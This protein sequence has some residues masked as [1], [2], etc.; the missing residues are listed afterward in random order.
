MT[1]TDRLLGKA[2]AAPSKNF[3]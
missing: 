3:H 1:W 2:G